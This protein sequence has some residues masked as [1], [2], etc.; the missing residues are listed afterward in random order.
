MFKR[1]KSQS[2][3]EN[4]AISLVQSYAAQLGI[5]RRQSVRVRYPTQYLTSLPSVFFDGHAIRVHD[6][7]V[8]GTC[9]I[10][11]DDFLGPNAGIELDLR[12]IWPDG[13]RTVRARIVSRVHN[14]RH[15]QFV[16]LPQDLIATIKAAIAPGVLGITMKPLVD[17]GETHLSIHAHE[18]WTSLNGECLTFLDDVHVAAELYLDGKNFKFLR[19]AWPVDKENLPASPKEVEHI[20]VFLENIPQP[21]KALTDLKAQ[22]QTLYFEGRA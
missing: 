10:D 14:R 11:E 3:A 8:G 19:D 16:N 2:I 5:E 15:I 22:L 1:K 7:S 4:Q 12:M 20:L 9:L 17:L 21:T 18:V 13:E 6:M